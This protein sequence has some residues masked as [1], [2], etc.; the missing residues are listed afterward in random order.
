MKYSTKSAIRIIL[1]CLAF[2]QVSTLPVVAEEDG[3]SPLNAPE[4]IYRKPFIGILFTDLTLPKA[5]TLSYNENYGILV[6]GIVPESPAHYHRLVEQDILMSIDEKPIMD[7]THLSRLISAHYSGEKVAMEVFRDGKSRKIPFQF[8]S[9]PTGG[10]EVARETGSMFTGYGGGSVLPMWLVLDFDDLDRS[11]DSW[12]F[13]RLGNKGF[14]AIGGGGMGTIGK[15]FL[16][17]GMGGGGS[18]KS[19]KT[20]DVDGSEVSKRVKFSYSFGGVTLTKRFAVTRSVITDLTVLAGAGHVDMDLVNIDQKFT[21]KNI[22]RNLD[23]NPDNDSEY[24]FA[25]RM[26]SN[27]FTGRAS[28]GVLVR[29][30]AWFGIYAS[31]GYQGSVI[32]EG[33]FDAGGNEVFGSPR[34]NLSGFSFTLGPWLGF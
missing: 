2:L 6:T 20:V 25:T 24:F 5:R 21:W 4:N 15:G 27:F 30:T 16:I 33:G 26:S 11:L 17:G 9:T 1:V 29:L 3:A 32:P 31:G 10:G 14:M 28:V 7:Q 22:R 13:D 19:S 34:M 18:V 12:G 8:G 23:T